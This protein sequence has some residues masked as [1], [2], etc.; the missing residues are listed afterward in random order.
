M[1]VDR[2]PDWRALGELAGVDP[3]TLQATCRHGRYERGEIVFHEGDLA[4][5]LHLIDRGRVAVCLTTPSGEVGI[6]D[7]LQPG[8]T[9][10]E[11]ALVDGVGERT[12]TVTALEHAVTRRGP[13]RDRQHRGI[14]E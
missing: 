2:R 1:G 11:Q 10:G 7:V 14:D 12:A 13:E 3:S 6:I 5:A 4:G 8:E 9:F